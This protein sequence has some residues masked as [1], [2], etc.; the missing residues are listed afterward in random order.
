[1]DW[2]NNGDAL[3]EGRDFNGATA[4]LRVLD[5]KNRSLDDSDAQVV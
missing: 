5:P 1:M 2:I 3:E 4:F